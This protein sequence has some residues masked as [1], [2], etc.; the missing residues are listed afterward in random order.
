MY[1]YTKIWE[2]FLVTFQRN[3]HHR[4][5]LQMEK[6]SNTLLMSCFS[7]EGRFVFRKLIK[8][9]RPILLVVYWCI[10][11][12]P[13]AQ[14]INGPNI[15]YSTY[16]VGKESENSLYLVGSFLAPASKY[17]LSYRWRYNCRKVWQ[18]GDSL[19]SSLIF[20]HHVTS[21]QKSQLPYMNRK[22]QGKQ[23]TVHKSQYFLTIQYKVTYF[24][25][26]SIH[27]KR[28]VDSSQHFG[29]CEWHFS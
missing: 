10:T 13:R 4:R 29:I 14:S 16:I 25:F 26:C 7:F 11:P 27:L 12:Y 5:R 19:P 18:D 20:I 21:S 1:C 22:S 17:A 15:Y 23:N 8:T 3:V 6:K 24:L 2:D 9:L 28:I